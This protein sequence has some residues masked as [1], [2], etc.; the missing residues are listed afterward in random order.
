MHFIVSLQ[1]PQPVVFVQVAQSV[2]EEHTGGGHVPEVVTK[3][4]EDDPHKACGHATVSPV[5]ELEP[6]GGGDPAAASAAALAVFDRHV[7]DVVHQPHAKDP[8]QSLQFL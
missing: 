6:Q 8:A 2:I 4:V 5:P 1:N 3:A 7:F